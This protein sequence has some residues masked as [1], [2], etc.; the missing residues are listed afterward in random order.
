MHHF[1]RQARDKHRES[2][3]KKSG[4]SL[5]T[6]CGRPE[7]RHGQTAAK[8]PALARDV[9]GQQRHR[10]LHHAPEALAVAERRPCYCAAGEKT[11]PLSTFCINIPSFYQDGL[12]TNIG[13]ALKKEMRFL[14]VPGDGHEPEWAGRTLRPCLARRHALRWLQLGRSGRESLSRPDR[15]ADSA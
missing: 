4:V 15:S 14:A 12:G 13:K 10:W 8:L 1:T 6:W 3:Q 9:A 11:A 2:T 5:G 7:K